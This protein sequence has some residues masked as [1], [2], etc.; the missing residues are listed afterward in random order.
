[1]EG[2]HIVPGHG[3]PT[4]EF[5]IVQKAGADVELFSMSPAKE[6]ASDTWQ[7]V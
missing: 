2:D 5:N 3:G 6:E 1:M 4:R 7:C